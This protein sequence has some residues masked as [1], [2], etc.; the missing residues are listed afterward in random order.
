MIGWFND[1][2]VFYQIVFVLGCASSVVMFIQLIL[3]IIGID[4]ADGSFDGLDGMDGSIDD[5]INDGGL[6]DI[7][8]LRLLTVRN[9]FIFLSMFCWSSLI[10]YEW[11]SSYPLSIIIAFLFATIIVSYL[12][13]DASYETSK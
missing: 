8:G 13:N 6:I 4:G 12:C 9:I 7:F 3:L 1:L 11:S 10:I 5:V 2:D